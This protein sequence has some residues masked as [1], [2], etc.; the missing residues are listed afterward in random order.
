ME[1]F[2]TI[3]I[4]FIAIISAYFITLFCIILTIFYLGI[5]KLIRKLFTRKPKPLPKNEEAPLVINETPKEEKIK[6]VQAEKPTEEIP[7][8]VKTKKVKPKKTPANKPIFANFLNLFAKKDKHKDNI[9]PETPKDTKKVKEPK[10]LKTK[11]IK[12]NTNK[13]SSTFAIS[14]MPIFRKLFMVEVTPD[15]KTETKIE[16]SKALASKETAKEIKEPILKRETKEI[17]INSPK[18]TIEKPKIEE[19]A[20]PT[21]NET[22]QPELIKAPKPKAK[23]STNSTKKSQPK[24][25]TNKKTKTNSNKN[26]STKKTTKKKTSKKKSKSKKKK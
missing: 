5:S 15:S 19:K 10:N 6:E 25:N 20:T 7:K 11:P 16:A 14:K 4:F 23:S 2:D 18:E 21:T 24:K 1:K 12:K 22:N 8:E 3:D 26:N 17:I 13:P 9:T